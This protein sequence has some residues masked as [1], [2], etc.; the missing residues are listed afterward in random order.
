MRHMMPF[1]PVVIVLVI[2]VT[3]CSPTPPTVIPSPVPA[4][5]SRLTPI[6]PAATRV[7]TATLTVAPTFTTAA[8][9]A[10]PST[11]PA[12]PTPV[13]PAGL[14]VLYLNTIPDPP[15]RGAELAFF[16]GFAN[17]TTSPQTFRW[18]VYIYKADNLARSFGETTVTST[19]A[20][21]GSEQVQSLGFWKLPLGGPCEDY[22]ARVALIDQNN[23]AAEFK[24]PNGQSFAKPMTVCPP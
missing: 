14:Y 10:L 7:P 12:P 2:L 11:T 18:I 3:A 8:P 19:I 5:A 4:S 22:V 20:P 24:M 16:A 21:P 9:T 1:V 17:N 6:V 15:I 13:I 23:R